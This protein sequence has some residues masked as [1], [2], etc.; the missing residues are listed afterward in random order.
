MYRRSTRPL[1]VGRTLALLCGDVDAGEGGSSAVTIAI[2]AGP[3]VLAVVAA[4][5]LRRTLEGTP[6]RRTD[7]R[8]EAP[9]ADL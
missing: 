3:L 2:V 1:R 5:L 4:L 8:F 6:T 9:L 7:G